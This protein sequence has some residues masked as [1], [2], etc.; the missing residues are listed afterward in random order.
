MDKHDITNYFYT[1]PPNQW[2]GMLGFRYETEYHGINTP[3]NVEFNRH[4]DEFDDFCRE[5]SLKIEDYLPLFDLKP[6]IKAL[7]VICHNI[8]I[9]TASFTLVEF[10]RS[11]YESLPSKVFDSEGMITLD[12]LPESCFWQQIDE[13]TSV[14]VEIGGV[15]LGSRE[16]MNSYK[17]YV[18]ILNSQTG[19]MEELV[20]IERDV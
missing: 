19:D 11:I 4:M 3:E 7:G 17:A 1:I 10:L 2:Q 12:E 15:E 20:K 8:N 16:S 9:P 14:H 6:I 18:Y 5:N 13:N